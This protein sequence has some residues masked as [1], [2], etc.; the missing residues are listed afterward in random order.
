M[1][2]NQFSK[3]SS[4][5]VDQ[6]EMFPHVHDTFDSPPVYRILVNKEISVKLKKKEI[7]QKVNKKWCNSC[8]IY[9]N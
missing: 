5:L 2:M 4:H 6:Q 1:L 8:F 9:G 7:I 3:A